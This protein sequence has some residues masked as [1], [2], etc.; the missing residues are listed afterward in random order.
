[1]DICYDFDDL[2]RWQLKT[3]DI[4]VS[5]IGKPEFVQGSSRSAITTPE[6]VQGSSR[7]AMAP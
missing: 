7:S 6:F 1:M 5:A 4:V 3:A 2:K